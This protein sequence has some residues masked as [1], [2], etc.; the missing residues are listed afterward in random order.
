MSRSS[1]VGTSCR[2]L[3]RVPSFPIAAS[4]CDVQSE[5]LLEEPEECWDPDA[6]ISETDCCASTHLF[7]LLG[8][9]LQS[10]DCIFCDQA[11]AQF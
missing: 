8:G 3:S 2:K 6:R 4:I 5:T 11:A 9:L 1:K 7:R 10:A